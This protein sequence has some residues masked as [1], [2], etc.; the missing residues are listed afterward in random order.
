MTRTVNLLLHGPILPLLLAVAAV[1]L[2][3]YLR[4]FG[5]RTAS[6]RAMVAQNG[7]PTSPERYFLVSLLVACYALVL[8]RLGSLVL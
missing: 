1:T 7:V 4:L 5:T 6:Y 3:C 2:Y 8:Y